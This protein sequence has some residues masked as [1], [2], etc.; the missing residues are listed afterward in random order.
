MRRH[1]TAMMVGGIVMVSLA[2]FAVLASVV[3]G[4][5][6][7]TCGTASAS[8]GGSRCDGYAWALYGG[9]VGTLVLVGVGVPLAMAGAEKEPVKITAS[10]WLSASTSGLQL[11]IEM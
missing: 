9:M 10:P 2:P 4:L 6:K 5:G 1:S 8:G 11:R 7:V 3:G